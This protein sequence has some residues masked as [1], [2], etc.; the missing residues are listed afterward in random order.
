[1]LGTHLALAD[2]YCNTMLGCVRRWHCGG[3]Q[4]QYGRRSNGDEQDDGRGRRP[5]HW[6][7]NIRRRGGHGR[8]CLVDGRPATHAVRSMPSLYWLAGSVVVDLQRSIYTVRSIYKLAAACMNACVEEFR[9]QQSPELASYARW[10]K[11]P[12]HISISVFFLWRRADDAAVYDARRFIYIAAA[13]KVV[14]DVNQSQLLLFWFFWMVNF[15]FRS[16]FLK[17][18]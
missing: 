18:N 17:L 6:P 7:C 8:R 5:Q 10:S 9:L 16:Q 15:S 4:V 12:S 13:A 2:A 14:V 3:G 1:M 11:C